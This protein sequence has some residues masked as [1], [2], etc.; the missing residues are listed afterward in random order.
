MRD[1]RHDADTARTIDIAVV[2][3]KLRGT[4]EAIDY[5]RYAHVAEALIARVLA[6]GGSRATM[7]VVWRSPPATGEAPCEQEVPRAPR[8]YHVDSRRHDVVRAAVV[9]AAIALAGKMDPAR[10]ERLLRREALSDETIA[11]VLSGDDSRRR[12]R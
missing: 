8:F 11:R 10:A 9:Q 12:L 6:A 7:T 4:D 3:Q 5:L 2:L 1:A